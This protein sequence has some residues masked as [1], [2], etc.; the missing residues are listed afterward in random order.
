MN[1]DR[2]EQIKEHIKRKFKVLDERAE[3]LI[4]DTQDGEIKQGTAEVIE[5]E[6]P[7]GKIKLALESRPK[8]LEKKYRFSHRQ[9]Q[10]A[11]VEYKHSE[12]EETHQLKFYKWNGRQD[13]WEELSADNLEGLV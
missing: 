9:G 7:M 3:D 1:L 4:M 8:I 2:W 11:Q 13:D 6:T 12:S 5:V 10:S